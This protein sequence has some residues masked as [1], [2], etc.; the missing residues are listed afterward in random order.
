MDRILGLKTWCQL[1]MSHYCFQGVA[2]VNTKSV[3]DCFHDALVLHFVDPLG[4][5]L[6]ALLS[7]GW[8]LLHPS[9]MVD[10][11]LQVFDLLLFLYD[12]EPLTESRLLG[13]SRLQIRFWDGNCSQWWLSQFAVVTRQYLRPW[14]YMA[15]LL[16]GIDLGIGG[17]CFA[18][19][20]SW[21]KV[22]KLKINYKIS[23][24]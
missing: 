22:D 16:I 15:L 4:P 20:E 1:L 18:H 9:V 13:G 14:R 3:L 2:L 10:L 21:L 17:C 19:C 5:F 8:L 23:N 6:Q 7:H 12:W 24:R 11:F